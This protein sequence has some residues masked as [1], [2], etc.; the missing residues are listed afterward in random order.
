MVCVKPRN[1]PAW[2]GT[3]AFGQFG[4]KVSTAV[5]SLPDGKRLCVLA[6]GAGYLVS[7]E[8]PH[9]WEEVP[10]VPIIDVREASDP[11]LVILANYTELLAYGEYGE[12]WRTRRLAWDGLKITGVSAG[13][14]M[15]EYWD[16]RNDETRIFKVDL[17]T[18]A[19]TGGVEDDA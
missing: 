15:G 9:A 19:S 6:R 14:I 8:D 2:F 10:L 17:A 18:G 3:F 5:V 1:G 7:A 16:M 4:P 13:S 11:F 12:Q